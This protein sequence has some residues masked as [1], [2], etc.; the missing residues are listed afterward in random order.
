VQQWI[1]LKASAQLIPVH[2]IWF[3]LSFIPDE[4]KMLP[5]NTKQSTFHQVLANII[6]MHA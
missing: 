2:D 6:I 3:C 4:I 5:F 1:H